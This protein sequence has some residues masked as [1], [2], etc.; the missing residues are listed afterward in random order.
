MRVR[1]RGREG[2][3]NDLLRRYFAEIGPIPVLSAAEEA[4]LARQL[5]EADEEL[6]AWLAP[7]PATAR[8]FL[9]RWRKIHGEGRVTGLLS[10]THEPP[11]RDR[12]AAVDRIARSLARDLALAK[13]PGPRLAQRIAARMRALELRTELLH[14]L[15]DELRAVRPAAA[16]R[17]ALAAATA[18]ERRGRAAKDAFVR[19]NL[20][21]V[22]HQAKAYRAYGVPF[23][24]LIQEGTLGLIRAVEKFDERLGNRFATYATW[25]IQQSCIRA[26]QQGART[27]RIPAPVQDEMRRHRRAAERHA[28]RAAGAIP[29][30]NLARTL[31]VSAAEVDLL[32][33][34]ERKTARL[35]D[36]L[37]GRERGTLAEQLV[38]AAAPADLVVA[39]GELARRIA[40][41]LGGLPGRDQ[42]ILKA[43]FGFANGEGETLHAIAARLGLS[44]ERVRQ[45]EQRELRRIESAAR[46]AG[47]DAWLAET[48][49]SS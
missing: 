45:L 22:V 35:D 15:L 37:P 2:G 5:R 28:V 10:R 14:E 27:V 20:R 23:L 12:S 42:A 8:A 13:R 41:L 44:R 11:A 21:L 47:L 19:H 36:P 38:D 6:R 9:A 4:A 48:R 26:V 40:A 16:V 31:G 49:L 24:D 43:R 17:E 30:S 18:A 33:R 7:L 3:G 32:A 46:E 39:R 34:L 29:V 25:W 1:Q